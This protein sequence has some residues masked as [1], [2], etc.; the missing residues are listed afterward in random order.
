MARIRRKF[1]RK[2][3]KRGR[4]RRKRRMTAAKMAVSQP[5]LK[6]RDVLYST[7]ASVSVSVSNHETFIAEG[8]LQSERIGKQ[9]VVKS[10]HLKATLASDPAGRV[11][12][13][14]RIAVVQD[15]Q[16]IANTIS[17]AGQ[18]WESGTD[19]QT[20]REKDHM[21]RFKIWWVRSFLLSNG[22]D[23]P[24][25]AKVNINVNFPRGLKVRYTGSAATQIAK[26]GLYL[27]FISN[28]DG[29]QPSQLGGH[30]RL[31]YY[32]V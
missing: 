18:V 27:M 12:T 2:R 1:R 20:F 3:F 22:G 25:N 6:I 16:Q 11:H 26:N 31:K 24:Q 30:A 9:I 8:T 14:C 5:E 17:T 28:A 7:T 21:G 29:G 23:M 15:K 19:P 13:C 32:D 4:P 10:F